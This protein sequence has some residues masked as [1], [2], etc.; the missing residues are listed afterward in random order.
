LAYAE[1]LNKKY[2]EAILTA[3]RVHDFKE[4]TPAYAYAHMIAAT[5]LESSDKRA[6]AIKEYKQ[7]L[8]EAPND[9]RAN[10]ARKE[11]EQL[12]SIAPA[13]Q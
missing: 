4:H 9:P 6:D 10:I 13:K 3:R 2:E 11:L 5:A 1:A 12:E 8:I 7:F